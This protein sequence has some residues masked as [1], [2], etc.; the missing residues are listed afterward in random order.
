MTDTIIESVPASQ[1]GIAASVNAIV[2]AIG[3][4]LGSAVRGEILTS[5][6]GPHGIPAERSFTT[7][8][9]AAVAARG[10]RAALALSRQ[11]T[12]RTHGKDSEPT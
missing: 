7:G 12:A 3:G 8:F 10:V 9:C 11:L 6:A 5:C 4:I 1:T 2:R